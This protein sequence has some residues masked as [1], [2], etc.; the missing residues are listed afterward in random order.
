VG[1]GASLKVV[2]GVAPRARANR[3]VYAR[4]SLNEWYTNGPLGLE[5]GFT[6]PRALTGHPAGPLTFSMA[7][8]GDVRASLAAGGQSLTLNRAGEV[9]LRYGGLVARDARG[10]TL[11]CWLVLGVG[12]VLLRVETRGA[13]YP[14]TI[15]PMI[16]QGEKLAGSGET[17][18]GQFGYSVALSAN[19]KTAL[20]GGAEDNSD[21]GAVWVFTYSGGAWTQQGEK[22]AGGGETGK[23]F[24]GG[25]VAL[26]S[27]GN[28]AL[29]GGSGDDS[30][31]GAAWVFTRSGSTWTQQGEK[32][33]GGG[34]TGSGGF[35]RSV[36][37]S[38][39]GNT[40]LIGG[41]GDDSGQGAAWV[42]T[43]SGSTWTQQGEKLTGGEET[44]EGAFGW[45]V[46]LSGDG[47]TA[48]IGGRFDGTPYYEHYGSAWVF[49]RS[50][51]KWTQQGSKLSGSTTNLAEYGFS[52][53]L[54][55]NGNTAV[56]GG[57]KANGNA[58]TG[59]AWIYTRTEGT[60]TL[61]QKLTVEKDSRF[62]WSVALSSDGNTALIGGWANGPSGAVWVYKRFGSTWLQQGPRLTG[63]GGTEGGEFGYSVA[64]SSTASTGL[65][66]G[67]YDN[68]GV[69]AAWTFTSIFSPEETYGPENEGEPH[70]PR[71]VLADPVNCATGNLTETQTDLAVGGR[72]PGLH[73]TRTY[74][75]QLAVTQ[76]EPGP[77]GYGW[78]G[79][80]SAHLVVNE[81]TETATVYQDNGSTVVF[82]LTGSKTYVGASPLVQATL[83]KEGS[84][85]VYTLPDQSKLDFNSA[86]QL[87]SETDRDGNAI[88]MSRNSE[89]RLES[90][91]DGAGRKLTFSYDSEGQVESV[92]DPMGHTVKY[93]Y[94]SGNLATVTQPGEASVR[95]EFHYGS[96]H[97][98][99]SEKD[100]RGNAVEMEY[101][102]ADRVV[103]QTDALKRKHT[104]K[105]VP[106]E[107]GETETT[108]TEPNGSTT[109]EKFNDAG[110]PTSVTRASGTS[111]AAT[112]TYEYNSSDELIAL[113]DPNKHKVEYGYDEAGDRTSEK[114]A[115]SDETKWK[116]DS[117]HDIETATTPDG[118]TTT[119]KRESHGN[120]EV[121]ERPAPGSKTQ[122]T[123]YKYDGHGDL[124]SVTNPLEHTWKYEYDTNGDRIAEV[125]PEGNKR[126]WS[127]NEDSQE[128][129]TV[130]PRGNVASGEPVR[131]TTT[132][133]R[134]AQGWPLTLTEPL[135]E[136]VYNFQFGSAGTGA[137]Q[138]SVPIGMAV[139]SSGNF[140]VTDS[141]NNRLE[142]FSASGSF[143]EAIGFGVS[144]GEEKYE[145]CT[146]SC[147]AGILGS[148][149]GQFH[150]PKDVAINPHTGNIYVV[151]CMND[152]IDEF[153]SEATFVQT[154]GSAGSGHGDL[155]EPDGMTIDSAGNLWV[156]D[157]GNN[158][159][160]E[161]NESGGYETSFGSEG[162]GEVQFKTPKSIAISGSNLY[163]DDFKNSRVEELSP[164]GEYIRQ[165]GTASGIGQLKEPARISVDPLNGDLFVADHGNN[166]IAVYNPEGAFLSKFGSLG[167]GEG[168]FENMKGV[169][170]TSSGTV[171]TTDTGSDRVEEWT[172]P[173]PRVTKYTYD[174]A[175]NLETQTNPDGN[176]T[177]Y[178]Y[179]AD[180][181]P[182]K[183]E[184]PNKTITETGYDSDGQVVSQTDGNKHTTEYVR[185]ALEEVVEV[186]N[187]LKQK[188]TKE[189]DATGNLTK[190]T[191]PL[192]RT[193]TNVYNGANQ[194][195]EVTYSDGKTPIVKYEYNK[196]GDRTAMTDGTGTSKYTYDQLDRLTETENGHKEKVKYEYDLANEQTKI[197]Y[198][199][200][201]SITRTYDKDG[202]LEK[203]T[204]WLEHATKFSYDADSDLTATIFPSETTD[205]DKYTYN[206]ADQMSEVKMV[207]GTETLASLLYNR[208][209]DGQVKSTTSKGLPGEEKPGYEYDSNSRLT[210]GGTTTYEYD[211]A[212]NPTK[213]GTGTY[214]YNTTDELETGPS[215]TYAYNEVGERTKTTPS[216]GPAT[217]YGYDEAGNL[218]SV[219]RPHEG[220]IP[221][222]EDSY[223]SN[224]EGLR[225]SQ[226]IS[227][228][229]S[230]LTWD[231][232][233]ELPLILSDG[234]NSYIYGPGGLPVEQIN[235]SSGALTYLHHD[236]AGSTR[237]LT[238]STGTVT[239]KCSYAAYGTP[240]CEGTATTPLGFDGEYTSADTGLI[241]MRARTYDPATAQFL[242]VDPLAKLTRAPY[243]FAEDNPLNESDP[244]GLS[245]QVCVGG[246]VSIGIVTLSGEACYV[247][248][249]GGNGITGTGSASV[250]PGGGANIHIGA[251]TSNACTPG[252]YGGP[253]AVAGGSATYGAGLYGT[254][255]TNAPIP[256]HGRTVKGATGG[257]TWGLNAETGAGVSETGVIPLGSGGS[258]A[259]S[260]GCGG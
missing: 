142:K 11:H 160:E 30:G 232:T 260:C 139:E 199:N 239:G 231:M 38:S 182:I 237:L 230:Y 2:G 132:I 134:D 41:S 120:P 163:V 137:G 185:N 238:G 214:K 206:E 81:E 92:T 208:D 234:T 100:G 6:V 18:K 47:N 63:G 216:T 205:E 172:A 176:E 253:F 28:T 189:Y 61:Q 125:D 86:G 98:M 222:I 110:L 190:V 138:F 164:K 170:V 107:N 8:S 169:V 188:T 257:A 193:T 225:A 146:S 45:S 35:G 76:S 40:A 78:T 16:Q 105:Y 25:S 26:S 178:T 33:T 243:N 52:V 249:P 204:D 227:G 128:I 198:P 65:I 223:D 67:I 229:T 156:A 95:W 162:S 66:G 104:W 64:L 181:E 175:G 85:Y 72:G 55:Y 80:Y 135:S 3:V 31:Q 148:G 167:K 130:S 157:S 141:A 39:E 91:T 173:S 10:R 27:N 210:K 75:S 88:T 102:V 84:T 119:I 90:V 165:F 34:E 117:T 20:V 154:I 252:E 114:D 244:T 74:N 168:Q 166:R 1:Y 183:V 69:G 111:I 228:T 56:V 50:E 184:E 186:I 62:G 255:F 259:S 14:L 212:N 226:T 106:K 123:K 143:I 194:L 42:F 177:T 124:E 24:F 93:T 60:W 240:T 115:D 32:L 233:E 48:L 140:W 113:T 224:G 131:Y 151:D 94:T 51:G 217:T 192:K 174:G 256:G 15:D 144:N 136:A 126:T 29:I 248:T 70:R 108:V 251:G 250:G 145:I 149:H 79:P 121:I 122:I 159:V 59:E 9:S 209:K 7:L 43:R 96:S 12:R 220:E 246:T 127:Y 23:G 236:Q 153:S 235:N 152:R 219:E 97:E 158:R 147:R 5:Q 218:M 101:E 221:K 202:R 242:T 54:S 49:T 200:E 17:G 103:T 58:E 118:E 213:I 155:D 254:G 179:D 53:A 4:T 57:P 197:T 195:V 19:G 191:D 215:L 36:A 211:A 133:E 171:Y 241:Y 68:E 99:L 196:D 77:F 112:T 21:I 44:K 203:V 87:T 207:K 129:S 37:L 46:A 71:C 116:Y 73:M 187:P 89:G 161:F 109:V 247:E 201:K 180:N 82:N 258:G 150:E 22:L 83:V 245:W 13:H